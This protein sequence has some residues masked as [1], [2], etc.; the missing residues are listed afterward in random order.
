VA[1]ADARGEA[2]TPPPSGATAELPL[3]PLQT[4]LLPDG[5]LALRV[6]EP[7]Y[8]DLVARCLRGVNRFGVVAIRGGAEVGT[9]TTYD[10]GT[11]AEIVDW[12]Q[13]SGG[14][15]GVIV[16]GRE[17]FRLERTSRQPDGLYVGHV[18]WLARRPP[19]PLPAVHAPL[20]G[21]LRRLLEQH[22]TYVGVA[23][24]FDDAV[25]VADRLIETLPL[26]LALKQELLETPAPLVQLERLVDELRTGRV[27]R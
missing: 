12:Q 18:E 2:P 21:L 17:R 5:P 1:S 25:W 6:F 14:M 9:A 8:V 19:Q 20:V 24:A 4:V 27:G 23:T 3:F 7:R 13:E 22:P 10:V 26:E 15:L 11:A 16:V